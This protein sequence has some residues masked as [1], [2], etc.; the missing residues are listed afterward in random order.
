MGLFGKKGAVRSVSVD[1][2][3]SALREVMDPELGRDLV[4]LNMIRNVAVSGGSVSLDLVL[5]TPACP[6]K[7]EMKEAVDSRDRAAYRRNDVVTHRLM[8]QMSG[9]AHLAR[10][11]QAM[12]GPIFMLVARPLT[13]FLCA[14]PDRRDQPERL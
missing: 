6:K 11:L 3:H 7:A 12:V 14:L 1:A 13:V 2:V 4:T 8:W 10:A 5:T 9:N